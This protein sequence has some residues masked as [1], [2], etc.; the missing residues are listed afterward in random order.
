MKKKRSVGV[1]IFA[2]FYIITGLLLGIVYVSA[3]IS[4]SYNDFKNSPLVY[5]LLILLFI[6]CPFLVAI[7]N[8]AVL[9]F[10][11]WARKVNL[12]AVWLFTYVG[13]YTCLCYMG[14]IIFSKTSFPAHIYWTRILVGT[15]GTLVFLVICIRSFILFT[16]PKVKEQFK[17]R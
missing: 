11:E 15:L 8:V 12:V 10:K 7:S 17:N 4:M 2:I 1:T 9:F 3:A 6:V 5:S 16:R 14:Y 13:I